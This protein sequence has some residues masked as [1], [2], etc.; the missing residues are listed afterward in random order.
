[1]GESNALYYAAR[2][3]L[4][5]AGD[6]VTAPEISQMF[7]E[8]IG[9]WC[10]DL[11]QRAG[12]P[13]QVAYAELGPGRG[14]LAADARRAMASQGLAADMRLVE[15]SPALR[16]EQAKRVAAV[17]HDG[18][19]D[20][21]DNRPLLIVANE[22]F[23]ALPVRQLVRTEEGWRERMV[24]LKDGALHFESGT[25]PMDEAVPLSMQD[26]EVGTILETNP[27]AAALWR[28]LCERIAKQGGAMLAIDYGHLDARTGSTLQAVKRHE[29]VGVFDAP[30]EMDLTAHVDF[31]MLAE[32]A[33]EVGLIGKTAEQGAWLNAL[34]MGQRARMLAEATPEQA[35]DVATA[36][37]RLT[38]HDEMGALFK[39][40]A[41]TANDWPQPSGFT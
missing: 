5:A 24:G 28:D 3:P 17:F 12:R 15:G 2:D 31:A 16:A 25:K 18:V 10:A 33:A 4:G 39:V 40:I 27:S 22:F 19:D 41:V 32:I 11:W 35:Q 9:L 26:A 7:G 21:P 6:F 13:E 38:A 37:R 36:Y 34:G 23:D 8:M 1:M 20:L 29:K 14:T 30:G